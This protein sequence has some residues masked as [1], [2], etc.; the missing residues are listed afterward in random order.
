MIYGSGIRTRAKGALG[1]ARSLVRMAT[2]KS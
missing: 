1:V 2:S